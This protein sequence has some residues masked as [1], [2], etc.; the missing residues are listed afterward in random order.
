LQSLLPAHR[1]VPAVKQPYSA[2]QRS[3]GDQ[4]PLSSVEAL[5]VEQDLS[6]MQAVDALVERI[7]QELQR[8]SVDALWPE[9]IPYLMQIPGFGLITSMTV[10]AAIGD[11]TRFASAKKLVG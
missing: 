3:W 4:L 5:R 9:D 6:I 8:L 10:F 2:A 1:I 7:G 11:I